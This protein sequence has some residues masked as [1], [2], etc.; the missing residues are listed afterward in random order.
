[1]PSVFESPDGG[2]TVYEREFG[3]TERKIIRKGALRQLQQR[4]QLWREIFHA[5]LQDAAL[6][7]MIEQV[8]VYY[9]L[10]HAHTD[11]HRI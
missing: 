4:S 3:S 9:E 6:Q 11:H 10:K 2:D 7:E 5:A 1:M 8:E